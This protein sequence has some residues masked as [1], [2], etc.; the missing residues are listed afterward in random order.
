MQITVSG[1]KYGMYQ[2]TFD[3][4]GIAFFK[5]GQRVWLK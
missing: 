2:V 4:T 3:K 5:D 1:K